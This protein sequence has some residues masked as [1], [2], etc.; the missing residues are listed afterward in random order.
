MA[1]GTTTTS[2]TVVLLTAAAIV[3]VGI[4]YWSAE[5]SSSTVGTFLA[6]LRSAGTLRRIENSERA[7]KKKNGNNDERD[8]NR[9][10][11]KADDWKQAFVSWLKREEK[12]SFSRYRNH[13]FRNKK[14]D[15]A[16][17]KWMSET[18][19]TFLRFPT[20][21][22][23][24]SGNKSLIPLEEEGSIKLLESASISSQK[25]VLS[26]VPP[27]KDQGETENETTFRLSFRT[28][29][30]ATEEMI[31]KEPAIREAF[32]NGVVVE[33][34][35]VHS[36][37][38]NKLGGRRSL[39]FSS[40]SSTWSMGSYE[41]DEENS[42]VEEEEGVERLLTYLRFVDL[43]KESLSS[44][45]LPEPS[46]SYLSQTAP[47]L[48]RQKELIIPDVDGYEHLHFKTMDI[49]AP[50]YTQRAKM[51]YMAARHR[52]RK[53]LLIAVHYDES[54]RSSSTIDDRNQ[55]QG[56]LMK[57]LSLQHQDNSETSMVSPPS[58]TFLLLDKAV[59]SLFEETLQRYLNSS[60]GQKSEESSSILSSGY[61]LVL[62][63]HSLGAALVCRL[64]DMLTQRNNEIDSNPIHVRVYAFGPPPCLP[65]GRTC[66]EDGRGGG[67]D[68]SYIVSVVNNH[69]C[70]PRWTES[71]LV[72][73]KM[74]LTWTMDRKQ[75]HFLR[76]HNRYNPSRSS[77]NPNSESNSMR[78][79]P[80][81]IPPF[82]VS[83]ME[84]N[85]FWK[86]NQEQNDAILAQGNDNAAEPK[87]IVPGKVVL[88]WNHSKDPNIIGA[89][90]HVS[91]TKLRHP[92][93]GKSYKL[94]HHHQKESYGVLGRLWVDEGMFSDHT[95][96][97]YRSNLELLLGQV[98][99][100]I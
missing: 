97:S 83:S 6:C 47:S 40:C 100:T 5:S 86:S 10:K 59:K 9:N 17:P 89:K 42:L 35:I 11:N 3:G 76:Y 24:V 61:S 74:S 16:D 43:A 70:I 91:E 2:P 37:E 49:S 29:Q 21:R 25:R 56:I 81:R 34:E 33:E 32:F 55:I 64:G 54:L 94:V 8:N 4:A 82:S 93:S 12:L 78:R 58:S 51:G 44:S 88:I 65:V 13:N 36:D 87:Y 96:D 23:V 60:T 15:L 52:D 22:T 45:T 7:E 79:H 38:E 77:A 98:G 50:N 84:W 63:G 85:T 19:R 1:A 68:Y 28:L 41:V 14:K 69:D 26:P 39:S 30:K 57:S 31:Q 18:I 73:L 27:P 71:N 80:P 66:C 20:G 99:N 62:C 95:I 90:V 48:Q 67:K 75:R 53:E 72:G 92:N 46:K